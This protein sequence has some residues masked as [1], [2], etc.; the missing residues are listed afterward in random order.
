MTD[1]DNSAVA[2]SV[3]V[4]VPSSAQCLPRRSGNDILRDAVRGHPR[5]AH[6]DGPSSGLGVQA[7]QSSG[8][9]HSCNFLH[10]L[11]VK[12]PLQCLHTRCMLKLLSRRWSRLSFS[13]FLRWMPLSMPMTSGMSKSDQTTPLW[14]HVE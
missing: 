1:E 4:P 5:P 7:L 2:L 11:T 12:I 10:T 13:R 9:L 3:V 8:L 14:R 6:F